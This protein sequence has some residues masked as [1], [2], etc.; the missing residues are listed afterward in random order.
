MSQ[1]SIIGPT[2]TNVIVK[3]DRV[4]HLSHE[5]KFSNEFTF[6]NMIWKVACKEARS[7]LS[8][9]IYSTNKTLH[10]N[11][12]FKIMIKIPGKQEGQDVVVEAR[13]HF[14]NKSTC[15][16]WT[17]DKSTIWA[18]CVIGETLVIDVAIQIM[19]DDK[20]L[21]DVSG[22]DEDETHSPL[23]KTLGS[24][25]NVQSEAFDW[26]AIGLSQIGQEGKFSPEFT[27]HRQTWETS[28]CK[29]GVIYAIKINCN[30]EKRGNAAL[31]SPWNVFA[32]VQ[33]MIKSITGSGQTAV[34]V[35]GARFFSSP[36]DS[37]CWSFDKAINALI[38]E[39]TLFVTTRITVYSFA[40]EMNGH[41]NGNSVTV[42]SDAGSSQDSNGDL[43]FQSSPFPT[44]C[45]FVVN[46]GVKVHVH[47]GVLM[48]ASPYF[49]KTMN[50][51]NAVNEIRLPDM[52]SSECL[53]LV[54]YM[55]TNEVKCDDEDLFLTIKAAE[56]F[57]MTDFV[58]KC[59]PIITAENVLKFLDPKKNNSIIADCW[60]VIDSQFD[61]VAETADFLKVSPTIM[62][63]ILKR[64]SLRTPEIRI[65]NAVINWSKAQCA[66]KAGGG[67]Q[68]TIEG[69]KEVLRNILPL[70]RFPIM[71]STDF[72]T[73][74]AA[75]G[76]LE[77][78]DIIDCFM[79]QASKLKTA[80]L[81][82]STTERAA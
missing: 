40:G 37:M 10:R 39:D 70:I 36:D 55:Y 69:Q 27:F 53:S 30:R 21:T 57:E 18:N 13:R 34:S 58:A 63:A 23:Y 43:G 82:F 64:D 52:K 6:S 47:K 45:T 59:R 61:A 28:I 68:V 78:T 8:F 75:G 74:P 38:A 2:A 77:Q 66:E 44:N 22:G 65:Y 76:F 24:L 79:Y 33:V 81:A 72:G 9:L 12:G 16:T 41:V 62:Q 14:G 31:S 7:Y 1:V 29:S 49:R 60:N 73:G 42:K 17:C 46:S 32:R 3:L 26:K 35:E 67:D 48:A 15:F 11:R 25:T 51:D 4:A 5:Y 54:R 71:N 19:A 20:I 80:T 56:K 50:A